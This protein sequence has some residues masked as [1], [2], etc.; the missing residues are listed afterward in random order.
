MHGPRLVGR[1]MSLEQGSPP[2]VPV[3]GNAGDN[4]EAGLLEKA[5]S[6]HLVSPRT[7]F[8]LSFGLGC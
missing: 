3:R 7:F 6:V 5:M 4:G 8:R 1:E 2:N